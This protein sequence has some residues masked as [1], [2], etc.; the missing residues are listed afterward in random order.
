MLGKIS[1][2][3]LRYIILGPKAAPSV[4][5]LCK[6]RAE[7]WGVPLLELRIGARTYT[8]FF[9]TSNAEA[10]IWSG[11]DFDSVQDVCGVCGEPAARLDSALCQWC[12]ISEEARESGP[13]RS[14]L[15]ATLALGID[16]GLPM[17]FANI[18]PRGS[19]IVADT[20]P[21]PEKISRESE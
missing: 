2:A 13:R 12:S 15:T 10:A 5:D 19:L 11:T 17:M 4:R 20:N 16:R 18:E 1:P 3:A 7:L 9:S 21:G 8:P 14:M 6:A